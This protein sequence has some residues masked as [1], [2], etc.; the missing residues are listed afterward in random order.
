MRAD[1]TE[2]TERERTGNKVVP[3]ILYQ[4]HDSL[5]ILRTL[6]ECKIYADTRCFY[7]FT[8]FF[9][10]FFDLYLSF[11]ISKDTLLIFNRYK[12]LLLIV[13]YK[14]LYTIGKSKKV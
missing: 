3:I 10:H 7:I 4:N 8:L 13:A 2:R 1:K 9:A 11:F 6:R 5:C 14:Y 12:R